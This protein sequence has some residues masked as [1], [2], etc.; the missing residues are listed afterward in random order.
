MNLF[1]LKILSRSDRFR[2][3]KEIVS[4]PQSRLASDLV[5]QDKAD[6]ANRTHRCPASSVIDI[7]KKAGLGNL[8]VTEKRV[9]DKLI[10]LHEEYVKL[11]KLKSL[12]WD[13]SAAKFENIQ[14]NFIESCDQ[15][16]DISVKDAEELLSNDRLRS[17][18]AKQEDLDFLK[19]QK[20]KENGI[21]LKI[22]MYSMK[23]H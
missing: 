13:S 21:L 7:W 10:Q 5:C 16:F 20:L 19:D 15:L 4:C 9:R 6:C 11:G 18:G 2:S 3:T 17:A 14:E 12:N 8:I 1:S 23:S 22:L